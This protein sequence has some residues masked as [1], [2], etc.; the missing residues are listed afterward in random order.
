MRSEGRGAKGRKMS[1]NTIQGK[2][3]R[4]SLS[5][6]GNLNKTIAENNDLTE[7]NNKIMIK[8]TKALA[9]FTVILIAIGIFQLILMIKS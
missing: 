7:K 3:L 1:D 8:Y 6:L 4:E 5:L 9:I 2:G